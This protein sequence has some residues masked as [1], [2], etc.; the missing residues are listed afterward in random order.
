MNSRLISIH[1]FYLGVNNDDII[2]VS[3]HCLQLRQLDLLGSSIINETTI[4]SILKRCLFLQFLDLSFCE[5]ISDETISLWKCQYKNS[6][7]R[8][9]SP[10]SNEDIYIEFA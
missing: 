6:F 9:Y 4:E 8:S 3:E 5:K 10:R 2:S 7:K 1:L